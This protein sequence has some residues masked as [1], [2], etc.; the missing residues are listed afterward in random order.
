MGTTCINTTQPVH[1]LVTADIEYG[2]KHKVVKRS[3]RYYA[4]RNLT[5]G[6]VSAVVAVTRGTTATYKCYKLVDEDMGPADVAA[7]ASILNAL[8]ATSEPRAIAWRESCRNR[9]AASKAVTAGTKIKLT[10][11]LQF[12]DGRDRDTFI[13]RKG[14]V[15]VDLA[16]WPVQLTSW[17]DRDFTI[18]G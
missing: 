5:D 14:S 16:G 18:V 11:P 4:V 1:E 10:H 7:P 9:L 12:T 6:S 2:G 15:F 17:R 8:T 3:G 13:F